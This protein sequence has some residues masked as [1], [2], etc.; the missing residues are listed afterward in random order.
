M[1]EW[2]TNRMEEWTTNRMEEWTKEWTTNGRM[3]Y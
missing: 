1:E 2:T 3:D